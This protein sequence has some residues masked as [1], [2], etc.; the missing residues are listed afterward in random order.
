MD[1]KTAI[2]I[3]D[4]E[5]NKYGMSMLDLCIVLQHEAEQGELDNRTAAAFRVFMHD[6]RR[7]FAPA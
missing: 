4:Q 3:L 6:M 2:E 5:R 7:M 1:I